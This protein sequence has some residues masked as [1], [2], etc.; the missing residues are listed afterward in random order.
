MQVRRIRLVTMCSLKPLFIVSG[1]VLWH[2]RLPFCT[3]ASSQGSG[4][5]V[6]Q[7]FLCPESSN[8]VDVHYAQEDHSAQDLH[9][10]QEIRDIKTICIQR[11][12]EPNT[13]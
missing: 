8:I 3:I 12:A 7:E 1:D 10:A 6:P 9:H 13:I 5:P 11:H 4:V 2:C